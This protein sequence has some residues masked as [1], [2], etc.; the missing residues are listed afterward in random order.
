MHHDTEK[1]TIVTG[2]EKGGSYKRNIRYDLTVESIVSIIN[3][4][5]V[6]KQHTN[7]TCKHV[8]I[9][10]HVWIDGR[11][12]QKLN[13]LGGGPGNG[14]GC[15]CGITNTCARANDKCNCDINDHKWRVDEG[16]VT[17]KDVL[18]ITAIY[19]GDTGSKKFT[20]VLVYTVGPLICDF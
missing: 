12:G 20:E 3:Q 13:F 10:S 14:T 2:Y 6:C 17:K 19:G 16:Y 11:D 15:A 8:V 4:S 7:I 1:A 18:P 9:K 5:I